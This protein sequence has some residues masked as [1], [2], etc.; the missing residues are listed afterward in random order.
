MN[1]PE[2]EKKDLEIFKKEMEQMKQNKEYY[3]KL[4]TTGHCAVCLCELDLPKEALDVITTATC[5]VCMEKG[6]DRI[7]QMGILCG[8][9]LMDRKLHKQH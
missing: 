5:S 1:K 7:F 3:F 6:W 4:I 2:Q 9:E 8:R